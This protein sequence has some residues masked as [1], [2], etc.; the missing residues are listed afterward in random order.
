MSNT[1][2]YNPT[3]LISDANGIVK[4]VDFE[5]T[6]SDGTDTFTFPSYTGLNDPESTPI[7]YS[8]LTKDVVVNWVTALVG[9]Q[10]QE[11]ADAELSDFKIR[12]ANPLTNGTPWS[13]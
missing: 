7:P 3:N 6:V 2:S 13:E 12:N 10:I 9:Q 1:Y 8:Q 4:S 11:Q 5:I